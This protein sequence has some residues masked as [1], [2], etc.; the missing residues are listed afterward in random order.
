[1][2]WVDTS[3]HKCIIDPCH[4]EESASDEESQEILHCAQNDSGGSSE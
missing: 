2:V 1:M 3:L 4:S